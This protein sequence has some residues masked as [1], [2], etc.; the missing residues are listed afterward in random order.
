MQTII[1]DGSNVVRGMYSIQNRPDFGLEAE[2]TDKLLF[3]LEKFN[4]D[5]DRNIEIY[6]DGLK[7]YIYRPYNVQ[8]FFSKHKKADDLIIN[9]VNEHID[10][11]K[12]KVL[13]ITQDKELINKCRNYGA[14]IQ[15]TYSF[16]KNNLFL[17]CSNYRQF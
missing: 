15:Y 10:N 5:Q 8:V 17:Y 4:I 3:Y 6:F 13:L 1:I 7:R 9:S 14:E 16:L 2:L 12:D 11:Y